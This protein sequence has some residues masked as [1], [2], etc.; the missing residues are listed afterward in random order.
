MKKDILFVIPSLG[1]GGAEKALVNLLNIMDYDKYN[2][3][4]FVFN[5]NGVFMKFVPEQVNL[6]SLPQ[7][8]LDFSMSL[9]KSIKT[10]LKK[11]K[12]N[13]LKDRIFFTKENYL[14]RKEKHID[15]YNWRY[16]KDSFGI[17]DKE[18]DVAIGYLEK[19][20]IYFCI[21]NVKSKK[22][23]GFIHSDYNKIGLNSDID[24]KYF[25][26]LDNII[27]VSKECAEVSKKEFPEYKRK[28][29]FMYNIIS[30]KLIYDMS[31][32]KI[33][34]DNSNSII[35]ISVGRL[36]NAKGYDMAIES[37]K[38]LV[39]KGYDIRWNII[40]DGEERTNLEQRI[41]KNNLED[42]FILL[43]IKENPYPYVRNAD[44]YVQ[45][46]RFEGKSIAIDEAK[47]LNKPILITNF[48]TAKDQISNGE[49]GLI[50]DMNVD[51][52]VKGL[53]KLINDTDLRNKLTK[54]LSKE[55]LGTENEINKLYNLF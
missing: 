29:N 9:R 50:V 40:G 26:Y 13:I 28:I 20:S 8:Y 1:V 49:D 42:R 48:S 14:K 16:M 3:D 19:S 45:T 2:V 44:I 21:D 32:E 31:K 47:I 38:K 54:N 10:L 37:C 12:L 39:E 22:K 55:Q 23:I 18:Y 27:T 4:L 25:K 7:D 11:R 51:S 5:H 36:T 15:Q 41:K 30:P 35:L 17:L 6:L 33:K 46:S 34:L 24:R 43:G 53:E 52:I